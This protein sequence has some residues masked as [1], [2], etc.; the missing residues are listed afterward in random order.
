MVN[1]KKLR[2]LFGC[3]VVVAASGI[4]VDADRECRAQVTQSIVS[5]SGF[6]S[7][8]A[9]GVLDSPAPPNWRWMQIYDNTEFISIEDVG[10]Q[11][12]QVAARPEG[13]FTDDHWTYTAENLTLRIA[14]TDVTPNTG[15]MS[16]TYEDNLTAPAVVAFDGPW[17]FGTENSGPS[18]GPKD[19][20]MVVT[21]DEPFS[22]YPARGHLLLDWIVTNGGGGR[23][24]TTAADFSNVMMTTETVWSGGQ[25]FQGPM[26]TNAHLGGLVTQFTFEPQEPNPRPEPYVIAVPSEFADS[27]APDV[28]DNLPSDYRMQQ[29]YLADEFESL[30]PGKSLITRARWRTDGNLDVPQTVTADQWIA[31]MSTTPKG[32]NNLDQQFSENL[33]SDDTV[34]YDG[35]VEWQIT[36]ADPVGGPRDFEFDLAFETAFPYDPQQGNLLLDLTGLGSS[37]RLGLDF[38]LAPTATT[39]FIWTGFGGVITDEGDG[40]TSGGHVVEFTFESADCDGDGL[41]DIQ[42]ANCATPATID[43]TL[44]LSGLLKGDLDGNGTVE[45]ADFLVLSANFGT[46]GQYTEGNLDTIGDIGFPDFLILS[47]NFGK[48]SAVLANVPEPTAGVLL[49]LGMLCLSVTQQRQRNSV[50]FS[51][52]L[53]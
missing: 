6:A 7:V 53:P 9:D 25:D 31:R 1:H 47:S 38:S 2:T 17:V 39:T 35:P 46:S 8:E 29:L 36:D 30:P 43:G 26:A 5:P 33:G 37:E 34:V 21:L 19:F 51:S 22:Y 24:G 52:F 20:D 16:L 11:I 44:A 14:V 49:S 4:L 48:T 41:T 23:G 50:T 32:L 3:F 40:T 27:E 18:G 12:T 13:T 28:G 10:Y 15:S 45:F 42:D